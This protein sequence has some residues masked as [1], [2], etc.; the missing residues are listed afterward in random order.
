MTVLFA[1][2]FSKLLVFAAH[3]RSVIKKA[4]GD[5]LS[6]WATS[7]VENKAEVLTKT[8]SVRT[9]II[10]A[11]PKTDV[12]RPHRVPD[13]FFYFNRLKPSLLPIGKLGFR[14]CQ[15]RR[16]SDQ[17]GYECSFHEYRIPVSMP[18]Q[19]AVASRFEQSFLT[20]AA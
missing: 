12:L 4:D 15:R 5:E 19:I 17:S 10:K 8:T 1:D 9:I 18:V 16:Q 11:D 20:G 14:E 13:L 7:L 2:G 6:F 3:K